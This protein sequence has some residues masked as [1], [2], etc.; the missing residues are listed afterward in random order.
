MLQV[1]LYTRQGALKYQTDCAP[2]NG[3]FM[4][5]IYDKGDFVLKLEPPAGWTFGKDWKKTY[6]ARLLWPT[7]W[8]PITQLLHWY[9]HRSSSAASL[10]KLHCFLGVPMQVLQQ[11]SCVVTT[12]WLVT[13]EILQ[14]SSAVQCW[15]HAPYEWGPWTLY[16]SET[17]IL[18]GPVQFSKGHSFP[19]LKMFFS[20]F[21]LTSWFH[22]SKSLELWNWTV[23]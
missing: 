14:R 6:T 7:I 4:I 5:P 3:Y 2:N 23:D 20:D 9:L 15:C 13:A 11:S 21:V 1:K 18:R 22:C 10:E 16:R 8:Y 12:W 19:H 17:L